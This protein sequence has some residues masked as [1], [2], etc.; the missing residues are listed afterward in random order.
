MNTRTS[1]AHVVVAAWAGSLWT[2]CGIVAPTLFAVLDDRRLAGTLAG[3]FFAIEAWFGLACGGL[4][5]LLLGSGAD[6]GRSLRPWVALTALAPV[7]SELA[8]GP[9]LTAARAAGN[10]PLFGIL[11]TVSAVLF[12]VACGSAVVLVRKLS[13][14]AG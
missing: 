13:R 14:P 8:V 5:V 6:A 11:H 3:T 9:A 10:M 12:L 7:A 1:L 4:L 2:V